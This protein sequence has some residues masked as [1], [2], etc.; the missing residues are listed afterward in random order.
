MEKANNISRSIVL[1]VA[2]VLSLGSMQAFADADAGEYLG[3]RLGDKY[4]AG[5][6]TGIRKHITGASIFDLHPGHQDHQVDA[7]SI[8]VSPTTSIIGS[9]FGE[10]YFSNERAAQV[11]ADRYLDNLEEMYGHWIRYRRS[12]THENYQLWVSVEKRPPVTQHWLSAK[13][14]RVDIGLIYAPDSMGRSEWMAMVFMEANKLE[15]TARQ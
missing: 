8:Y 15:L 14:Y 7:I 13:R 12:L 11:F 5:K 1:L 4:F 2:V 3:Y 10:W 6:G 9:I